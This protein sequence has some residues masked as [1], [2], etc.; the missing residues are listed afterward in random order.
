MDLFSL[1]ILAQY[2][3]HRKLTLT[4]L[5]ARLD[6]SPVDL[7]EYV[8]RLIEGDYLKIEP[9]YARMHAPDPKGTIGVNVPLQLTIAGRAELEAVVEK[10]KERKHKEIRFRITTGI[11]VAALVTSIILGLMQYLLRT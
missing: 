5:G 11:A 2:A 9:N 8:L 6:C 3:S 1:K 7:A 10:E 4:E